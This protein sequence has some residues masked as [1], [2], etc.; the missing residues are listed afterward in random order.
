MCRYT[1]S[2][3][4]K[5]HRFSNLL[6]FPYDAFPL[7]F[8]F[9]SSPLLNPKNHPFSSPY[10]FNLFLCQATFFKFHTLTKV[11]ALTGYIVVRTSFL[12]DQKINCTYIIVTRLIQHSCAG[13]AI[14]KNICGPPKQFQ[15]YPFRLFDDQMPPTIEPI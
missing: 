8:F 4:Q 6:S 2:L 10:F 7:L 11:P 3:Q 5:H 1:L 14:E 9:T 13:H 12:L 15:A